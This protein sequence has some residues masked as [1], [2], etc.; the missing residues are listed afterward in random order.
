MA[1]PTDSKPVTERSNRS[2]PAKIRNRKMPKRTWSQQDLDNALDSCRNNDISLLEASKI[3]KIP[4]ATIYRYGR[5]YGLPIRDKKIYVGDLNR[6]PKGEAA[7]RRLINGYK[8]RALR[9][10]VAWSLLDDDFF[11]LTN[12]CCHYCGI[13]PSTSTSGIYNRGNNGHFLYNGIDRKDSSLGYFLENCLPC[14]GKCNKAKYTM[15][16]D[17]FQKYIDRLVFHKAKRIQ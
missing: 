4:L 3:F 8:R 1:K 7:K 10:N 11:S 14:C 5:K 13:E 6:L 2:S 15:A 9:R 12:E 16:Y 17:E